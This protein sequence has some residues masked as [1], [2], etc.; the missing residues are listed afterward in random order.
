[1]QGWRWLR[2][3]AR[4]RA[5]WLWTI[6]I[7]PWDYLF[8]WADDPLPQMV[9]GTAF[10]LQVIRRLHDIGV[11]GWWLVAALLAEVTLAPVAAN[12]TNPAWLAALPG[13]L[14]AAGLVGLGAVPGQ[15]SE[16]RFGPP[17][18]GWT[19]PPPAIGPPLRET[20]S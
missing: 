2:G 3:R 20:F 5:F 1:M 17:P 11:S 16:N 8:L 12:P 19:G 4:R 10:W 7:L 14:L 9:L 18:A 15:R 6:V 13:L